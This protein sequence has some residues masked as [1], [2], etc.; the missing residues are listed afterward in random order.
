MVYLACL[1]LFV[2]TVSVAQSSQELRSRYGQPDVERFAVRPRITAT[3]QYGTDGAA[4]QVVIESQ[5]P[6]VPLKDQ[7][8][9]RYMRPETVTEIIDEIVPPSAR[10]VEI[11][12]LYSDA[13]CAHAEV[14]EYS[15]VVIHRS[16]D[17]CVPLKPERESIASVVF[18]RSD[19]P[20]AFTLS[21]DPLLQRK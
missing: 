8:I 15:N 9:F 12:S 14:V 17:Q 2:S 21:T 6:L 19:C 7:Y 3:V 11:N 16:T 18:K 20:P 10:G 1:L 4:C 5:R 13:G